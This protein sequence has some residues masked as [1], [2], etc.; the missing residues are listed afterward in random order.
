MTR[1]RI[2]SVMLILLITVT[3]GRS[4]AEDND[5]AADTLPL[6]STDSTMVT[7]K[8]TTLFTDISTLATTAPA[9]SEIN[10]EQHLTQ[11][12]TKALLKSMVLPGWGQLGNK[13]YV[14]AVL[15]A[16]FDAWMVLSALHYGRQ[17]SDYRDQYN[18]ATEISL[19]NEYYGLYLDRK[20]E[21]N[22]FTWFAVITSFIAMFDAYVDA[23]LSGYPKAL[24]QQQLSVD[25]IPDEKGGSKLILSY[26]F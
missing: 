9:N 6:P 23:H 15:F 22:K 19:K 24:E 20:D 5:T 2:I 4:Y 16:G 25:V 21:R 10:Y 26:S 13:K 11:N 17:A 1:L 18:N 7:Q 8:D 3:A 12:P 14:K